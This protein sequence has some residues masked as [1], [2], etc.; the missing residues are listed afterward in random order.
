MMLKMSLIDPRQTVYLES[1]YGLDA[2]GAMNDVNL[3]RE[4]G[5]TDHAYRGRL[6]VRLWE[7]RGP[8]GTETTAPADDTKPNHVRDAVRANLD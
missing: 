6:T 3:P 8:M 1:G 4:A 5:E 7:W 2:I